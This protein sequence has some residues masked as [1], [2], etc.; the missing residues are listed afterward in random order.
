M[1]KTAAQKKP[2]LDTVTTINDDGSR[3]FLHPADVKGPFTFWRRVF[4]VFLLAIYVA[5]PWIQINGFPAVFLDVANRE[6]HFFGLTFLATDIWLGF[7]M[8][9]GLGFGLFYITALLGRLWCGWACPYTVFLEF[10]YRRIERWVDGPAIKRK[11]LDSAPWDG[12]KVTRRV[13]KHFLYILVSVVIAHVFVSYFVSIPRL[14]SYMQGSPLNHAKVFGV[15]VFF[16]VCLYGAFA[17]FREQFCIILCPYGR[18]QSALTDDDTVVI[19]YDEKRGE[20]RGKASNPS[21]GDCVACQRCV[22]VCPTGIDIRNGLQME[23]IGCAACIDACNEIM[24]KLGRP[25]GLVRYDSLNGLNRKKK[26]VIRPRIILYTVLMF[27]GLGVLTLS[28]RGMHSAQVEVTRMPGPPFYV[29]EDAVRNQYKLRL[30]SKRST[31]SEV[32]IIV[33][34]LPDKATVVGIEE[35][36]KL[37]PL[38]DSVRTLIVNIPIEQYEGKVTLEV[39]ATINPGEVE[40]ADRIEFIGPSAYTLKNSIN[41]EGKE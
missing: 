28:V 40:I 33:K 22:Q 41:E 35:V 15:I 37:S 9:T 7:F 6:F 38:E 39:N 27:I 24:V 29:T 31:E 19:G 17:W 21:N 3:Y 11:K 23:C 30:A 10:I 13:I 12:E 32:E 16:T 25:K 5:L 2:N 36:V 18:I 8:L 4:G 14:Y 20:P 1:S 26:R 34:G